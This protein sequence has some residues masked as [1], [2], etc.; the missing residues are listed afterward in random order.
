MATTTITDL[1]LAR[2]INAG[3]TFSEVL[4]MGLTQ[5]E[6]ALS[7]EIEHEL[8]ARILDQ[9]ELVEEQSFR[10]EYTRG[11]MLVTYSGKI[12]LELLPLSVDRDQPPESRISKVTIIDAEFCASDSL[13]REVLPIDIEDWHI[14]ILIKIGV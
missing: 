9:L 3:K 10:V 1:Q 6:K 2:I 4:E 7:D 11:R 14:E 13:M 5:A 12:E 8:A